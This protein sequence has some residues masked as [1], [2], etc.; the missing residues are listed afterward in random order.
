[1]GLNSDNIAKVRDVT[2]SIVKLNWICERWKF[3]VRLS[4]KK[5]QGRTSFV[6][7]P[8]RKLLMYLSVLSGLFFAGTLPAS[9]NAAAGL[10]SMQVEKTSGLV[11]KARWH[12][13]GWGHRGWGHRGWRHYG[14]R[15]GWG[16]RHHHRWWRRGLYYGFGW[17][18]YYGYDYYPGYYGYYGG[19]YYYGHR[20]WYRHG[21]RHRGW[22]YRRHWGYGGG[23]RHRG[24]WGHRGH[25]GGHRGGHWGGHGRH[26]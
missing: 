18:Y 17:P 2:S 3:A 7:R 20:R 11:T 4:G 12:G 16:Y 9:A 19:P 6:E 25:W 5:D 14:W 26:H 22:G 24:G 23:W 15:R 21:W 1:M 10:T 13:H 8:M